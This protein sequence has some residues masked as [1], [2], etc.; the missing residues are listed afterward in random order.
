MRKFI[1]AIMFVAV[2]MA[3]CTQP[4]VKEE[5]KKPRSAGGSTG[6]S[7]ASGS[8]GGPSDVCP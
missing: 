6:S 7:S 4:V 5:V 1:I 8:G 3:G 2:F